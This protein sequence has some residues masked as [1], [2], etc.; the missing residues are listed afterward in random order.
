MIVTRDEFAAMLNG[1]KYREEM[2]R[3]EGKIAA[4]SR[5]IVVFGA[6]DD[7]TEFRGLINDEAGAWDGAVHHI[8]RMSYEWFLVGDAENIDIRAIEIEAK[9]C[10]EGFEGY[11]LIETS[12]PHS[13]F[14]I[15]EDGEIYCR[16]IVIDEADMLTAVAPP[17]DEKDLEIARLKARI[18][19][20]EAGG[21]RR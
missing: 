17:P 11:W 4:E 8:A 20:L 2:T 15:M 3:A 5:L 6:S 16:G 12:L 9:W 18:L 1:R 19:E 13:R 7:L 10:P 21:E 14:D